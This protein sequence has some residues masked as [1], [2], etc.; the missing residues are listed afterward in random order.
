MCEQISLP[1]G[2]IISSLAE[3]KSHFEVRREDYLSADDVCPDCAVAVD[4]D[5]YCPTTTCPRF[6]KSFLTDAQTGQ[7]SLGS[8]YECCLCGVDTVSVLDRSGATWHRDDCML[9]PVVTVMP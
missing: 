6:Q 4:D 3:L 8:I 9:E 2:E 5:G 7:P 1:N